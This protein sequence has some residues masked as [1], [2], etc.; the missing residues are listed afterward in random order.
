MFQT[1]K[2]Y[3]NNFDIKKVNYV[4]LI[5]IIFIIIYIMFSFGNRKN[6]DSEMYME[7]FRNNLKELMDGGKSKRLEDFNNKS[8][9]RSKFTKL[10]DRFN[11]VDEHFFDSDDHSM[12]HMKH[13]ISEYYKSFDKERFTNTPKNSRH[14]LEKF[15]HFK[16]SFWNIFKD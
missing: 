4:L 11:R 10:I 3:I 2:N 16:E 9:N 15:Q 14:A 13:K 5:V 6:N 7:G 8:K 1:I 12:N